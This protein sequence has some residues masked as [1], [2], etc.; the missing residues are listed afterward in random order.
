MV[1]AG[2]GFLGE[3]AAFLFAEAGSQVLGL[4]A[5][6][7]SA[8]RLQARPFEVLAAD[9]AGSLS[10]VPDQWKKPDLLIHCASSHHGG[11]V[12]YR[13]VYCEGLSNL[14]KFFKPQRLIFTGSTSV[15]AQED[16]SWVEENSPA[17]PLRET[18]RILLDAERLALNAGGIVARLSGIYGPGRSVLLRNFQTGNAVLEAGGTRWINQ[19]HRDDAARALECL[20]NPAVSPGIYNVSDNTPA[21]QREVYGWIAGFLGKPLPPEGPVD[22]DRKRGWTNKRVNNG[23]LRSAGWNARFPSYLH[24]LPS[25]SEHSPSEDS[26]TQPN[27]RRS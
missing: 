19:I 26:Q 3:A 13:K 11:A 2:C 4:C 22:K 14:L 8:A 18:G 12:A 20:A 15:Y 10:G 25:L 27:R 5:T 7:K 23:K 6:E 17:E 16:G 9:I 1:I 24:A 21:T